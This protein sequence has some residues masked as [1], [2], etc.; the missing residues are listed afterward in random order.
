ML[1]RSMVRSLLKQILVA[2]EV[3]R[4]QKINGFTY[5]KMQQLLSEF[6]LFDGVDEKTINELSDFIQSN[7]KKSEQNG[8]IIYNLS[9]NG[10]AQMQMLTISLLDNQ[11]EHLRL[12]HNNR[13]ALQ[14]RINEIENYL[15]IEVNEPETTAIYKQIKHLSEKLGEYSG[16]TKELKRKLDEVSAE[17]VNTEKSQKKIIESSISD[18]ELKDEVDRI[19]RYSNKAIEVI[20]AYRLRL[21]AYKT[22]HLAS[23]VTDCYLK[24]ANKKLLI[25]HVTIDDNTLDFQ[26]WNSKGEIVPWNVISAGEKQLMVTAILWA[27]A[28]CS[29]NRLPVVIDTPLARL[30]S[31]HR[32]LMVKNYFPY[33]SD[34][35]VILSTDSEID[36]QYYNILEPFIGKEYY[37]DYNDET[38]S[39]T[40]RQGFFGGQK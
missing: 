28:K 31:A 16:K 24:I 26:Y 20:Q 1:F 15:M 14:D 33:A 17:I 40:V 6:L 38:Q 10:Y 21:Q 3:E 18:L 11:A 5:Q 27:L 39:T 23:V 4:E 13:K 25:S 12:L 8:E 22:A 32:K 19:I 37:L 2:S 36:K 9:E 30:D 34:Q 35:T 7:S 29:H